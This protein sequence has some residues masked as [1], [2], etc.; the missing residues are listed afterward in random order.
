MIVKLPA[1]NIVW[2]HQIR[3]IKAVRIG[4]N[5]LIEIDYKVKAIF[6]NSMHFLY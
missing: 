3:G 5:H 4:G 1:G 2:Y 6:I